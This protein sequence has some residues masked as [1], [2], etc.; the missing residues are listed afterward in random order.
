MLISVLTNL[1]LQLAGV[2]VTLTRY[3][4]ALKQDET[5]IMPVY[6]AWVFGIDLVVVVIL[7]ILCLYLLVFH[8]YLMS[9]NLTTFQHIRNKKKKR[10]SKII[11]RLNKD[12][13]M[14]HDS[15][16]HAEDH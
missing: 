10:A 16:T 13:K 3:W 15:I 6:M 7:L 2:L 11:H 1:S 8:F 9:Q 14:P 5:T 12:N 4:K